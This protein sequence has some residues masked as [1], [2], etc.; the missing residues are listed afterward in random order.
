MLGD[1][2]RYAFEMTLAFPIQTLL[3]PRTDTQRKS[4]S[5]V[6]IISHAPTG[7]FSNIVCTDSGVSFDVCSLPNVRLRLSWEYEFY[8]D[9][10]PL[11][12]N[13]TPC[14]MPILLAAARMLSN[15]LDLDFGF[16]HKKVLQGFITRTFP[17][18]LD[19]AKKHLLSNNS[20]DV[21][22][23]SLEHLPSLIERFLAASDLSSK[24]VGSL[25]SDSRSEF[26]NLAINQLRELD[27]IK[28]AYFL[29]FHSLPFANTILIEHNSLT[30]ILDLS[31]VPRLMA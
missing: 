19:Q 23:L 17:C 24:D 12:L 30:T 16:V 8:D 27:S 26:A 31:G 13:V 11:H 2:G 4:L 21:R 6:T 18:D 29:I 28:N 25:R 20:Y 7:Q 9:L 15:V 5:V 22:P 10:E 3:S 1:A 14:S